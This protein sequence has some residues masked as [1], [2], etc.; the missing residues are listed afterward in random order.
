M[1][2]F[3]GRA[4]VVTGAG[5]GL[6]R[7]MA[8]RFAAEGLVA[9]VADNRVEAAEEVARAIVARGHRALAACVDVTD[10][11]ALEG[12]AAR[13]DDEVGGAA[14]LVNNAG[15]I[16]HTPLAE[17]DEVGWRWIVDV[18]LMGIVHGVQAFLP[19]MLASGRDAHIVN[20][21]SLAGMVGAA[22]LVANR[23]PFGTAPP[24]QKGAMHGYLTTKYAAVGISESLLAELGGTRVG[25]SVLCP[26]HHEDTAIFENSAKF[27]PDSFGGPMNAAEVEATSGNTE[28]RRDET[29]TVPRP[30][31]YS[32][33]CAARVLRAIHEGH[34]YVFTH[35]ETRAAVEHRFT[36][37]MAGFDD[38]ANFS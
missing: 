15:V 3:E 7:A 29:Y 2:S 36:Q 10:A 34:F 37:V 13:L 6:G 23:F 35:P 33:E 5:S 14:V 32:D 16:S 8:E 28:R 17:T 38:S 9:V 19:R 31:R 22:G 18:N 27:R 26:S 25:V 11:A 30:K 20:V 4:A 12:L 21:A 1:R 24:R